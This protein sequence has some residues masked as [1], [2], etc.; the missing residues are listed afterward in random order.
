M[1]TALIVVDV[2]NCFVSQDFTGLPGRI[3]RFIE[4]EGKN[5]DFILFTQFVNRRGSNFTRLLGWDRCAFSPE[6]DIHKDL[7]KFVS[8]DNVFRK[9]AFSAFKSRKFAEFLKR[10]SIDRITIC[11]TDT[12]CCVYATAMDA[13]DLGFSDVKVL[14]DL[15]G[16]SHGRAAHE[17]GVKLLRDNL[18]GCVKM[19]GS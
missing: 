10:N 19:A 13:F 12:E 6:I 15:C 11:G 2:Q 18:W 7:Q 3:A 17:M 5:Y 14:T 8:R 9:C 16:S 1:K 4:R